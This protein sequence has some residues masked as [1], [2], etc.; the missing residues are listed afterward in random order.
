[1]WHQGLIHC[2]SYLFKSASLYIEDVPTLSAFNFND[3]LKCPTCL[4]TNLTKNFG[5][6]SLRETIERPYQGLFDDFAFSGRVKQDKEGVVIRANRKDV[7]G[8]NGE[9]IWILISDVQTLML[10][11]DTHLRKF[12]PVKYLEPFLQQYSLECKN[13]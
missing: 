5:K 2:G 10:H 13:K 8:M 3:T 7:E 6:K 4:K 12:P 11:G 1:M 9:T